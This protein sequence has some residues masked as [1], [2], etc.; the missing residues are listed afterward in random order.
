M[1]VAIVGAGYV[2]SH[3]LAA[4]KRLDFVDVV[5]ICDTNLEAANV[6]AARFGIGLVAARR[7]ARKVAIR[8]C[9]IA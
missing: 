1:R 4:L 6:L 9:T 8:F 5:G 7:L 3:H 2:A